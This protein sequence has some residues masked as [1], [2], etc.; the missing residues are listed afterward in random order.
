MKRSSVPRPLFNIS[1]WRGEMGWQ[2]IWPSVYRQGIFQRVAGLLREGWPANWV[3]VE[4][5]A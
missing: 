4:R 3:L 5:I 1:V 2:V